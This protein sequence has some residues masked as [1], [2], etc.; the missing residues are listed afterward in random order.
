MGNNSFAPYSNNPNNFVVQNVTAPQ[1]T[2]RIF[3]YP[4]PH[5][6][7]RDIMAIP[8]VCEADIR[9]SLLKGEI[10][11]KIEKGEI[12]ILSSDIDLIQFNSTQYAF[13]TNAGVSYGTK[14]TPAQ[15]SGLANSD[16]GENGGPSY[17][18]KQQIIPVGV[19]NGVNRTFFTPDLF[20]DGAYDGNVLCLSVTLNGRVLRKGIDYDISKTGNSPGTG[21]NT[22]TFTG[23]VPKTGS[24]LYVDY[25]VAT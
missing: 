18:L 13:L 5:G 22:I 10:R 21:F 15:A 1:K 24:Q 2:V 7:S 3:N 23:V 11:T 14:V 4:I 12:I 9:A 25:A 20:L 6:A 8:G 16:A 19:K 17:T